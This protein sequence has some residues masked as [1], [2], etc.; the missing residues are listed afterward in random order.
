[1]ISGNTVQPLHNVYQGNIDFWKTSNKDSSPPFQKTNIRKKLLVKSPEEQN[2][3]EG[4]FSLYTGWSLKIKMVAQWI[5][6]TAHLANYLNLDI[7]P[8]ARTPLDYLLRPPLVQKLHASI[9]KLNQN[10]HQ[11]FPIF[12][13]VYCANVCL[14]QCSLTHCIINHS[15]SFQNI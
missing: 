7:M 12:S 13:E 4:V 15:V 14:F 2:C 1:M 5:R 9:L 8:A 6:Q 11:W 10:V 3:L